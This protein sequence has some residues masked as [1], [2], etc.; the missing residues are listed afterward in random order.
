MRLIHGLLANK[1]N[2]NRSTR[3]LSYVFW[4]E[5][6][7]ERRSAHDTSKSGGERGKLSGKPFMK[8]IPT[9]WWNTAEQVD[10]F[11]P[12]AMFW[13][14]NKVFVVTLSQPTPAS[15]LRVK[16]V[17]VFSG[18]SP[19]IIYGKT[20]EFYVTTW[21]QIIVSDGKIIDFLMKKGCQ[22]RSAI[23]VC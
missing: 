20:D 11:W 3:V 4:T 9:R 5:T 16:N 14:N 19:P 12:Y 1:L 8:T 21:F 10:I 6:L 2:R 13:V 23:N 18:S 17:I 22:N 7:F 15:V